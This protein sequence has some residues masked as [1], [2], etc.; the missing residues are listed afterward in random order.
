VKGFAFLFHNSVPESEHD[1]RLCPRLDRSARPHQPAS[2]I[3]GRRVRKGIPGEAHQHHRR[4]ATAN[5]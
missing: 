3:E 2:P 4:P 5:W 1:L